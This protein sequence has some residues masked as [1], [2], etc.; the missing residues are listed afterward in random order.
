MT[1]ASASTLRVGVGGGPARIDRPAGPPMSNHS[2]EPNTDSCTVR[3]LPQ[4]DSDC[5]T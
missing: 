1:H 4:S 3:H 5:S 2:R